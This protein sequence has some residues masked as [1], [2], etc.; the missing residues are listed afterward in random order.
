M[1]KLLLSITISAF[2]CSVHAQTDIVRKIIPLISSERFE[3]ADVFLDSVL[4][5]NPNNADALMMKGNVILNR[6][7]LAKKHLPIINA[8]DEYILSEEAPSLFQPQQVP[9][10]NIADS[11]A[12]LW[13]KALKIDSSRVDL[14]M[15]L[16][17]LYGMSLQTD[18]L[19]KQLPKLKAAS[20]RGNEL[21][22]LMED[23]ARLL[24]ERGKVADANRVY[25]T[26][27]ALYPKL[28]ELKSDWAAEHMHNDNLKGALAKATEVLAERIPDYQTFSN[29]SDI[30]VYANRPDLA[31]KTFE[32]YSTTDTTFRYVG[33]YDAFYRFAQN[34]NSW[35]KKMQA[36]IEN[37]LF[38]DDTNSIVNL[39]RFTLDTA[40][41]ETDY[42]D[43]FSLLVAPLN[44]FSS[45]AVLTRGVTL[46]PDSV[47]WHLM[48]GELYLIGKNYTKANEH[49]AKATTLNL[50]EQ[51]KADAKIIHAYSLYKAGKYPEATVIFRQITGESNLYK[52]QVA[53][54]FLGKMNPKG[55]D[56]KELA[57]EEPISKYAKIVQINK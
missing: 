45:W 47:H 28:V 55:N 9:N 11:V 4:Q 16:C 21:A 29:L 15:G 38:T 31:L 27:E 50:D 10:K 7:L 12:Q 48:L 3:E 52:H 32:K 20:E 41:K 6:H 26:I 23:Y 37:P 1:K 17:T 22:Y 25:A 13:Q 49:F 36:L 54:Y 24:R 53:L 33:F 39:A 2:L 43:N 14:N 51:S 8:L 35:K 46:F 56:W 19:I 30:F 42:N 44:T 57:K 18:N 5:K 40:F 34:D